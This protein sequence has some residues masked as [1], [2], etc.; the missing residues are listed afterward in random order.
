MG[1]KL[2][3]HSRYPAIKTSAGPHSERAIQVNIHIIRTFVRVRE[4][5]VTYKDLKIQL[6]SLERKCDKQFQV[7]FRAIRLLLDKSKD[8]PESR[9]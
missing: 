5:A 3:C 7:V 2:E 4:I 1:I 8:K 6:D 9:F